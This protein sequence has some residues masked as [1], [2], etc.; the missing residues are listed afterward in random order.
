MAGDPVAGDPVAGDPVAEGPVD[1][2]AFGVAESRTGAL[3][4]FG[5]VSAGA[6]S[7]GLFAGFACGSAAAGPSAG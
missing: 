3:S 6:R 2:G 5:P 1:R 4:G 7:A